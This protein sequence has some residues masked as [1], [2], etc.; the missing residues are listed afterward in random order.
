MKNLKNGFVLLPLVCLLFLF[1]CANE[2]YEVTPAVQEVDQ[3]T[4][5][6][7]QN[8][9]DELAQLILDNFEAI[10]NSVKVDLTTEEFKQA[11]D[12][13]F[14]ASEKNLTLFFADAS[15][16]K[17]F[18]QK[19]GEIMLNEGAAS[20]GANFFCE[21]T[22]FAEAFTT[23]GGYTSASSN[24][25]AYAS[26]DGHTNMWASA[27]SCDTYDEVYIRENDCD[28]VWPNCSA[29][30]IRALYYSGGGSTALFGL[31]PC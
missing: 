10:E 1:S 16:R 22:Y 2:K 28:N 30:R 19:L 27:F 20:L 6:A 25:F 3:K 24:S 21:E 7:E 15:S 9:N 14:G 5:F 29:C 11:L 18:R 26:R 8:S 31:G 17:V 23:E 4:T 13:T 12:L